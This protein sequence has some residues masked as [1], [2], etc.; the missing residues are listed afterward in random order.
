MRC[1][2]IITLEPEIWESLSE[3]ERDGVLGAHG[4]F[5]RE[6]VERGELLNSALLAGPSDTRTVRIRDGA[7]AVTDG[8]SVAATEHLAGY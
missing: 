4:R 7:A 5:Q 6:V 8:A 3:E 1:L 2:M